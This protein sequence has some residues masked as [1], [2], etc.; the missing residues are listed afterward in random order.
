M[1]AK[2]PLSAEQGLANMLAT[3]RSKKEVR[4]YLMNSILE[5]QM[6]VCVGKKEKALS[7]LNAKGTL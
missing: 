2:F 6:A 4:L 5:L 7:V 1:T 3:V